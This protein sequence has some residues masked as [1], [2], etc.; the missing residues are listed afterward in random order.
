[1]SS[2]AN[3]SPLHI[4]QGREMSSLYVKQFVDASLGNSSY[5]VAFTATGL[6]A[7]IDPQCDI[8]ALHRIRANQQSGT[9]K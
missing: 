5:L 9:R 4:G 3:A 7:V 6:A 8:D 1:M 2:L